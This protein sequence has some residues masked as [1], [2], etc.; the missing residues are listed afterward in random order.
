MLVA[1]CALRVSFAPLRFQK[2]IR[3]NPCNLWAHP[4]IDFFE[5]S[6]KCGIGSWQFFKSWLRLGLNPVY[7]PINPKNFVNLKKNEMDTIEIKISDKKNL[8]FLI[9]LLSKFNFITEIKTKDSS[10]GNLFNKKEGKASISDF[11]GLWKDNPKSLDE[12]REKAW[13]RG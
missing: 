6:R 7:L 2:P 9:E 5:L 4:C 3:E 8:R 13:K 12:I 10:E 1:L 11:A